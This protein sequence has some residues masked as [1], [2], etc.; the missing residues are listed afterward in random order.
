MGNSMGSFDGLSSGSMS[1]PMGKPLQFRHT[2]KWGV[3]NNNNDQD[4]PRDGSKEQDR[5]WQDRLNRAPDGAPVTA[6]E[7]L[8][9]RMMG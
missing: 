9:R 5:I 3:W 1:L 8:I 4:L 2:E 6:E 7:V